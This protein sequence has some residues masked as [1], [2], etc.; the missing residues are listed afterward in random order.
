MHPV[1][2]LGWIQTADT[3]SLA[4]DKA[5]NIATMPMQMD[6]HTTGTMSHS[7]IKAT[8]PART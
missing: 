6:L 5:S 2:H 3:W 8:E 1:Q 7:I 4:Y